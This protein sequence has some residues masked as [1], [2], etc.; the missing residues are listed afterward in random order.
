MADYECPECNGGFPEPKPTENDPECP[1][2]GEKLNA[3]KSGITLTPNTDPISGGVD[4]P[5]NGD[6]VDIER[7][8]SNPN[9]ATTDCPECGNEMPLVTWTGPKPLCRACQRKKAESTIQP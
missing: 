8:I 4:I 5:T 9:P 6:P 2:C 7:D 3:E 1:W